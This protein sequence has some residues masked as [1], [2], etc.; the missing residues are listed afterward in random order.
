MDSPE[1]FFFHGLADFEDAFSIGGSH[2]YW[3]DSGFKEGGAGI[4]NVIVTDA[5]HKGNVTEFAA[6]A[7]GHA[8]LAA[9]AFLA[10]HGIGSTRRKG[11]ADF[12]VDSSL[13]SRRNSG[14]VKHFG[15]AVRHGER[16]RVRHHGDGPGR[17]HLLGIGCHDAGDIGPDLEAFR[18]CSGCING[19]AV[20]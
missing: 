4:G 14:R 3:Q 20:V 7:G 18:L 13:H 6:A 19:G 10:N 8:N 2:A 9:G 15:S 17:W 1:G 12:N 5:A 16:L 11:I